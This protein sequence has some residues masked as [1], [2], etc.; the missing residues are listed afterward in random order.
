M[1]TLPNPV[2]PFLP[3]VLGGDQGGPFKPCFLTWYDPGLGGTNSASGAKDPN[4]KTASGEPYDRTKNTC[5]APPA[6]KFGTNIEFRFPRGANGKTVV[7]KVNDRGGAIQGAHFDLSVAA[8]DALG[9]GGSGNAEFRVTSKSSTEDALNALGV[10]GG[11]VA[12]AVGAAGD[13][14]AAIGGFFSWLTDLDTWITIGKV[15]L[16]AILLYMGIRI[17]YES[18]I[19]SSTAGRRGGPSA[20]KAIKTAVKVVK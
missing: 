9:M 3:K 15:I 17:T 10:P 6:Y 7:C 2:P 5:A 13:V 8:R 4:A 19:G 20:A 16:G 14:A 12:G 1:S 11:P 18:T